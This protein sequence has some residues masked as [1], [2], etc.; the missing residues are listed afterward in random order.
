[1]AGVPNKFDVNI[2]FSKEI[3]ATSAEDVQREVAESIAGDLA[4]K[5]LDAMVSRVA[6]PLRS[7]PV[8]IRVENARGRRDW[9]RLRKTQIGRA[10]V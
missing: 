4:E 9:S 6:R 1:M 2:R 10:H 5:K 3:D 8:S 7:G